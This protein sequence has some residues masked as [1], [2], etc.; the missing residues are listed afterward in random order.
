MRE[1]D[2]SAEE[3]ENYV[4]LLGIN[5][6]L[7]PRWAQLIICG[8]GFFFGYMVNGICEVCLWL[9]LQIEIASTFKGLKIFGFQ[10]LYAELTWIAPAHMVSLS[11]Y[12]GWCCMLSGFC[13]GICTHVEDDRGEI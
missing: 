1:T 10:F 5:V 7:K 2:G 11:F 4:W 13:L 9:S 8:G 12:K 3:E 6:S